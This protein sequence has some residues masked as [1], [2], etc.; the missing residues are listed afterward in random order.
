MGT[1]TELADAVAKMAES[2]PYAMADHGGSFSCTEIEDICDVLE[3]A[4]HGQAATEVREGHAI[5]GSE[6]PT[7]SH[8]R[9]HCELNIRA[10]AAPVEVFDR[11]AYTA[12][13]GDEAADEL[14]AGLL[15]AVAAFERERWVGRRVR[16]VTIE[17]TLGG[18]ELG[19]VERVAATPAGHAVLGVRVGPNPHEVQWYAM[20]SVEVVS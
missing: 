12:E 6:E 2:L 4:G 10:G 16:L 19:A 15:D 1:P 7:D 20:D 18:R 13:F 8:Y 5:A 3:A 11:D 17:S 9:L 14:F